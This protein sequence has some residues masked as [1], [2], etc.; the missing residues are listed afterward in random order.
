MP[1]PTKFDHDLSAVDDLHNVTMTRLRT[2][3]RDAAG[4]RQA[5]DQYMAAVQALVK[6]CCQ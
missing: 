3:R 5:L 1:I 6:D 4:V 2:L